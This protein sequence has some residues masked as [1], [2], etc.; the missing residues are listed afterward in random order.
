MR[1]Q[2]FKGRTAIVRQQ[3]SLTTPAENGEY[4]AG[5]HTECRAEK[6]FINA[7]E[8][9]RVSKS[10]RADEAANTHHAKE[11]RMRKGDESWHNKGL[12]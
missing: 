6:A 1:L 7:A 2:I 8:R 11:Q 9:A 10:D 3:S 12:S 4:Q 5:I